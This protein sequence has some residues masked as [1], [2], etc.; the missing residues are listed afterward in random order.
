MDLV[1]QSAQNALQRKE[2]INAR[3]LENGENYSLNACL[4]KAKFYQEQM[5]SGMLGLGAQLL[6]LKVNEGHGN[7]MAAVEELGLSQTSA[8]Y[9]M[10][11]ALKFGNSPTLGNLGSSKLKALTVLDD[12][13]TQDFVNGE[14]IEGLG[15]SDDVAAMTVRE[16]RNALRQLRDEKTKLEVEHA[17]QIE[18]VENVV[19]KKESKI[20]ELEMEVAGK[21][22]PTKEELAEQSLK[23][24]RKQMIIRFSSMNAELDELNR[25]LARAQETEGVTVD[26]LDS[27]SDGVG[28][29]YSLFD[30]KYQD[31]NQDMENIR[32]M[33]KE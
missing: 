25:L 33:R 2:E 32:P 8:N 15:T 7:F 30:D 10:S 24:I 28:E 26:Q 19:R 3:F 22:S 14:K 21:Q 20:S 11:A 5:A 17:K 23:E 9:A 12:K 27:L 1:A 16:L 4:E 6:L 29:F 18:A 31:F 13:Q